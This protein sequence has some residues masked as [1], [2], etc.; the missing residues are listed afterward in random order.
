MKQAS[1]IELPVNLAYGNMNGIILWSYKQI[2]TRTSQ[3]YFS[4]ML[5]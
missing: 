3:T 2:D 5:L 4:F 1:R